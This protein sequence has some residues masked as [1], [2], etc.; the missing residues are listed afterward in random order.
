MFIRTAH[1]TI[2]VVQKEDGRLR[3]VPKIAAKAET[4][5]SLAGVHDGPITQ[6]PLAG[7]TV[8]CLGQGTE[9]YLQRDGLYLCAEG[10]SDTLNCN[11]PEPKQ[12][13]TFAL[14]TEGQ[15][16]A[17]KGDAAIARALN[18]YQLG[19]LQQAIDRLAV[20][21][22]HCPG[23][24]VVALHLRLARDLLNS[25]Q[26]PKSTSVKVILRC[27]LAQMYEGH[28]LQT[29]LGLPLLDV[30]QDEAHGVFDEHMIVVDSHIDSRKAEYYREAF[31]RGCRI[32]LVHLSD[33]AFRDD[34]SAYP[35][36]RTVWRN[37]WSPILARKN[38]VRFFPLGYQNGVATRASKPTTEAREF[39]WSFAGDVK[40]STR[41]RMMQAMEGVPRG[42]IH[43]TTY[44]R[45]T[46]ALPVENY[47]QM[48]ENSLFIPC[49]AGFV[50]LDSFRVYEALE[51]GSIPII[52]RRPGFDYFRQLLGEHPIPT[53]SDWREAPELIA[54]LQTNG[55]T[56]DLRR[57]CHSWWLN[58]KAK[59]QSDFSA[60]VSD[61][62]QPRY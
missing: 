60:T 52:E 39:V 37:Y 29:L 7:Y 45:S 36:C 62:A 32:I 11:R 23:N 6:G 58:H 12:W 43:L 3:H 34:T 38:N 57:S 27:K 33:E 9:F 30:I 16:Y 50:N 19:N 31:S 54:S 25:R 41:A 22:A 26:S 56:D 21:E 49:P 40:K 1:D 8:R 35:W 13:E 61:L 46:D 10:S 5:V 28:W 2:V 4:L 17:D 47:R 59:L 24:D 20:V 15:V 48:I 14:I 53:I 18:D 51:A 42:R 44:F 55:G